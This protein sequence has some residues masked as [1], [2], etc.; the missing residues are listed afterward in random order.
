MGGFD[1]AD[2]YARP[3]PAGHLRRAA[4]PPAPKIGV[5]DIAALC[6]AAQT[7]AYARVSAGFDTVAVDLAPF[8]EIARLLYDGPWVAERTAALRDIVEQRPDILYPTTRAIVEAGLQRHTVDAFA[9][10][11]KLAQARRL[12]QSIFT[13]IDALI[14]PTAPFTPTLAELAA[15]PI[16]PN[17]RLGSFTNFV[18]LCDLAAIAV[19]AGL[20]PDGLPTSVTVIGPAWSEGR[21]AA[22]ADRIHRANADRVG[23][24]TR[25]LPAPEAADPL[26][27]DET[28]LFCIGAHMSGLPLNGQV[29]A[30][31]GRLLRQDRTTATYRMYALGNRPGLL[32]APDG[33]AIAGEVWALPT[34]SIGALLAQVPAPLGFGTVQLD[35]GPCLGFLVEAEGVAGAPDIT[36]KGGWRAHLT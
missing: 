6:D 15:D 30:L 17:S 5:A 35:S 16:G 21:L 10:F 14:L 3:A 2:P 22:I 29:T 26:H 4:L 33:G 7:A 28:A 1:A 8:L 18:N 13:G 23:N 27:A 34:T 9:A 31:G 12:A 20:G 32:R 24:T 11:H 25:P 36:A 19:P